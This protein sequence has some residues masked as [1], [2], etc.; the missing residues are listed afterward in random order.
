[1]LPTL[2]TIISARAGHAIVAGRDGLA[3][4]DTA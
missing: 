1:M 4:P 3:S 2:A